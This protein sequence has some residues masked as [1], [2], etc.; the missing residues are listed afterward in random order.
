M[1]WL[2]LGDFN[3]IYIAKDKNN[4]NLDLRLM[5]QFRDTID[6]CELTEILLQ[7]HRVFCNAEWDT[8][9]ST[10]ALHALATSLSDHCPL[11]LSNQCGPRR[12]KSFKFENFWVQLPGFKET[13]AEAWQEHNDHYE[14]FH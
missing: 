3:L 12:H 6:S 10:H 14:P 2:L 1:G 8:S 11:L 13:V 4:A 9:F 5:R 7:N